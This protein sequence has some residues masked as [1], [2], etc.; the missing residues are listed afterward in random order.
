ML[1]GDR[2]FFIEDAMIFEDKANS[3]KA[4][5]IFNEKRKDQFVG[6]VYH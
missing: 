3:L 4:V 5:L 2:L 6:K 1:W